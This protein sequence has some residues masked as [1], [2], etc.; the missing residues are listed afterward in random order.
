MKDPAWARTTRHASPLQLGRVTDRGRFDPTAVAGAG[1]R[2]A[3]TLA[4]GLMGIVAA[5]T[6]V[7]AH[8]VG[9]VINQSGGQVI[10]QNENRPESEVAGG[11]S[12]TLI[13]WVYGGLC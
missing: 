12:G 1:G 6:A 8:L 13:W 4:F 5:S 10:R 7:G 11:V 2:L 9:E 3:A